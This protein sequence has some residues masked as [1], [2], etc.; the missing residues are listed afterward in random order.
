[1]ALEMFRMNL[2]LYPEHH[3]THS[4]MARALLASHDTVGARR[5]AEDALR[6]APGDWVALDLLKKTGHVP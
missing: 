4:D 6:R 2:E 5:E 3:S 1:M